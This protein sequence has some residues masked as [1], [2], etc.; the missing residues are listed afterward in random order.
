[1]LRRTIHKRLISKRELNTLKRILSSHYSTSSEGTPAEDI[2]L[3][4]RS[5]EFETRHVGPNR[6]NEASMLRTLGY[7]VSLYDAQNGS[8]WPRDRANLLKRT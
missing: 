1:M 3:L 8:L 6:E 2:G 5:E 7:S 4:L